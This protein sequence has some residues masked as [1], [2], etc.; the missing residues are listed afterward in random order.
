VSVGGPAGVGVWLGLGVSEG[1][2]VKVSVKVGR[3][4]RVLVGVRVTVEVDV[5]VWVIVG[6]R[7]IVGVIVG[8]GA[9]TT[10]YAASK[11]SSVRMKINTIARLVSMN[12]LRAALPDDSVIENRIHLYHHPGFNFSREIQQRRAD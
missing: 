9:R 10:G 8:G 3:G 2:R 7:V 6:V 5:L 11:T 12:R 4:V 1:V